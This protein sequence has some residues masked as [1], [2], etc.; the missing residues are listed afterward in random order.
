MWLCALLLILG[1][2]VLIVS[3]LVTD[4]TTTVSSRSSTS[5]SSSQSTNLVTSLPEPK[6]LLVLSEPP[7]APPSDNPSDPSDPSDPSVPTTVT[8]TA[9]A[10]QRTLDTVGHFIFTVPVTDSTAGPRPLV[11]WGGPDQHVW[12]AWTG[13]YDAVS[14][15]LVPGTAWVTSESEAR[16]AGAQVTLAPYS[17]TEDVLQCTVT[18]DYPA[19]V[20]EDGL[21]LGLYFTD[22]TGQGQKVAWTVRPHSRVPTLL[23]VHE[24]HAG[25]P[26]QPENPPLVSVPGEASEL[27]PTS[28]LRLQV[29]L[30]PHGGLIASVSSPDGTT[31]VSGHTDA[32]S[33]AFTPADTRYTTLS[34]VWV[35]H[36]EALDLTETGLRVTAV[37]LQVL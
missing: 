32:D 30:S 21:E 9:V 35:R 28:D 13:D 5:W 34:L 1:L 8:P 11:G 3:V 29:L 36:G 2:A 37:D 17:P 10:E 6:A 18:F 14:P 22:A 7:L 26:W 23:T 19:G 4:K 27:S 24:C 12:Q 16:V 15:V 33:S 20:T 25:Q 31:S